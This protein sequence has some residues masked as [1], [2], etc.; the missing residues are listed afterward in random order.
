MNRIQLVE[1]VLL[2]DMK[3][4]R[5]IT[6]FGKKDFFRLDKALLFR[7]FLNRLIDDVVVQ[8]RCISLNPL[9]MTLPCFLVLHAVIRIEINTLMVFA[10][11]FHK[12]I[13]Q[14]R[15]RLAPLQQFRSCSKG[16]QGMHM[17]VVFRIIVEEGT[18]CSRCAEI[19][20]E[21]GIAACKALIDDS[22]TVSMGHR[23]SMHRIGQLLIDIIQFF[24]TRTAIAE[25]GHGTGKVILLQ[26]LYHLVADFL[27]LFTGK[28]DLFLCRSGWLC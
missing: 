25:I 18:A 3:P 15:Q 23:W 24:V 7:T 10:L 26:E 6:I 11:E 17:I 22:R 8:I 4:S 21:N 27:T 1:G 20:V 5:N 12:S 13:N 19:A 16:L 14:F 9:N 2:D 28:L